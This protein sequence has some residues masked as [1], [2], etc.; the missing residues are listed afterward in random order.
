LT[1]RGL[2]WQFRGSVRPGG[3]GTRRRYRRATSLPAIPSIFLLFDRSAS[4]GESVGRDH[5]ARRGLALDRPPATGR[6]QKRHN[7]SS[8]IAKD[9]R[10]GEPRGVDLLGVPGTPGRPDRPGGRP[11]SCPPSRRST[12][13]IRGDAARRRSSG[14]PARPEGA[15]LPSRSRPVRAAEVGD[16]ARSSARPTLR[17]GDETSRAGLAP[18][19]GPL[20]VPKPRGAPAPRGPD[21][22]SGRSPDRRVVPR[23]N[24]R[25]G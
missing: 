22:G 14:W 1:L 24:L 18:C 25:K 17:P 10:R 21:P 13:G 23:R 15:R 20:K 7:C 8:P 16:F 19:Q 11:A 5:S 6:R 9:G 12:T 4:R 3:R 2:R